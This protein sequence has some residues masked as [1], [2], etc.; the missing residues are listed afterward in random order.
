MI[1][2]R[3]NSNV[4][5]TVFRTQTAYTGER[6]VLSFIPFFY[7]FKINRYIKRFFFFL[8]FLTRCFV[9]AY[10]F[11]FFVAEYFQLSFYVKKNVI[12]STAPLKGWKT[13][14]PGINTGR[15]QTK[16]LTGVSSPPHTDVLTSAGVVYIL[17]ARAR[18]VRFSSESSYLSVELGFQTGA[19][20]T[21]TPFSLSVLKT[22][23][24][25]S[26]FYNYKNVRVSNI[27]IKKIL[28]VRQNIMS[29]TR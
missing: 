24:L 16:F 3:L 5:R 11:F 21:R 7:A 27:D 23:R 6:I 2:N 28:N 4:A 1:C 12:R 20:L 13:N 26:F 14:A 18:D 10:I 15:R 17:D 29:T 8:S 9:C 19:L 22:D 25:A